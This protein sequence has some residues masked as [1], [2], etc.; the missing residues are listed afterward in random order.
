LKIPG[1][2]SDRLRVGDAVLIEWEDSYGC[3][4]DWRDVPV[5]G[6]PAAM[7]CRSLGWVLRASRRFVVII[8]HMA[9]NDRLGVRQ[10]CGDMTIPTAAIVRVTRLNLRPGTT[11][12]YDSSSSY[13]AGLRARNRTR[14]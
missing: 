6:E 8:P 9:Q 13:P 11:S 5:D 14:S 1:K 4:P 2:K 12:A 3:S 10:G 7:I